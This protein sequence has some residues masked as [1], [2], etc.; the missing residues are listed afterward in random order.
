[1]LQLLLQ[2]GTALIHGENDTVKAAKTDILIQDNKI[3]KIAANITAID[4]QII[5]CTDKVISER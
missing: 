2:N 5:D 4:A 3:A 1:M